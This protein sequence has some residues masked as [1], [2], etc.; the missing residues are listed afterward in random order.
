MFTNNGEAIMA[1]WGFTAKNSHS[2]CVWLVYD[3]NKSFSEAASVV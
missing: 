3:F 2:S 1:M